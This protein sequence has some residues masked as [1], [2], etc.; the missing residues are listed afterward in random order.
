MVHI[1]DALG[2]ALGD[3][4]AGEAQPVGLALAERYPDAYAEGRA[5]GEAGAPALAGDVELGAGQAGGVLRIADPAARRRFEAACLGYDGAQAGA[6]PDVP[7]RLR[8]ATLDQ[9]AGLP[10]AEH[11]RA[12]A[13]DAA[14]RL[15]AR[16]AAG[17]VPGAGLCLIGPPSTGKSAVLAA[18]TAELRRLGVPVAFAEYRELLDAVRRHYGTPR[19]HGVEV[20][21]ARC[22][23]VVLDDLGDPYRTRSTPEE[24]EDRRRVVH[25]LVSA[26]HGRCLPTLISAN[27]GDVAEMAD[28]FDPRISARVAEACEVV[29]VGGPDL[30]A[31]STPRI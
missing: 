5:E 20:S 22:P 14:R 12:D 8:A 3:G 18:A 30:R 2:D 28:Q 29:T 15:V 27:Y 17:G 21:L 26:R 16:Y 24:T 31:R 23:V 10:G 9:A 6:A 1:A 7:L 25:A 19:A 11:G 13:A 4:G